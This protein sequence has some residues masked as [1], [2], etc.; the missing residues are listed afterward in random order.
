M[1]VLDRCTGKDLRQD[2]LVKTQDVLLE[3]RAGRNSGK[4]YD[5]HGINSPF[6]TALISRVQNGIFFF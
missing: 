6:V 5:N 1:R 2:E 4:P 3:I